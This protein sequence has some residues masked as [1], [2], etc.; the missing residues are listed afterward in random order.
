MCYVHPQNQLD[1]LQN[2]LHCPQNRLSPNNQLDCLRIDSNKV[3]SVNCGWSSRRQSIFTTIELMLW[4]ELVFVTKSILRTI[5]LI[6]QTIESNV[7]QLESIFITINLFFFHRVDLADNRLRLLTKSI[8][9]T[10]ESILGM[11]TAHFLNRQF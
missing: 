9:W 8:L 3:E 11:H 4:P 5:K 2:Q 1:C 10:I 6:L 7:A